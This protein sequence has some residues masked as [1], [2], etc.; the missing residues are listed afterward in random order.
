[1]SSKDQNLAGK[2]VFEAINNQIKNND[3]PETKQTY[4]RLMK[5]MNSP[6]EVMKYIG[7]VMMAEIL[8]ILKSKKPFN[9]KG[10]I[11]RLN[12]LPDIS[13]AE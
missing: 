2:A 10:F 12:K 7:V 13:W 4:N 5:E 11:E 3:P 9:K 1:M 8:D 6:E